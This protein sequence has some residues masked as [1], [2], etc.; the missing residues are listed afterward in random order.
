MLKPYFETKLGKLY[1]CD[2]LEIMTYMSDNEVSLVLT[3]PPYGINIAT[4]G[5]VGVE[6]K[7]ELKDYGIQ[8]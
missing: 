8:E 4:K 6:V 7:A 3:D 5:T 1:N 2:C